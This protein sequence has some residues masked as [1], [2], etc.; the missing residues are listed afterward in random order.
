MGALLLAASS[1]CNLC[2]AGGSI[3]ASRKTGPPSQPDIPVPQ[4]SPRFFEIKK[5]GRL[6]IGVG[7]GLDEKYLFEVEGP[8]Q[9]HGDDLIL[10]VK[11]VRDLHGI[12]CIKLTQT[13]P[14]RPIVIQ[15]RLA[16]KPYRYAGFVS[17]PRMAGYKSA[18]T[19][20]IH[21]WPDNYNELSIRTA[22][23]TPSDLR[24]IAYDVG[25]QLG[26]GHPKRF[27]NHH[28]Q[29]LRSRLASTL[30]ALQTDIRQAIADLTRQTVAA[31]RHFRAEATSP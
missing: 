24:G 25:L 8:T 23:A 13:N 10:E 11:E 18:K 9:A 22:F 12:S 30:E 26:L 6:K 14:M 7:S 17:M 21:E 16:F 4:V 28:S 5:A 1:F 19:F 15:A 27:S 20:W 2:S 3:I 29:Q 31:W